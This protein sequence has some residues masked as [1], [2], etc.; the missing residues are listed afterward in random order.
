MA[1]QARVSLGGLVLGKGHPVAIMGVLNV[2]PESFHAGSVHVTRDD[3]V[4]AGLEMVEAGA[5]IL[6]VGA[7]TTAPYRETAID[8]DEEERRLTWAVEALAGKV[9]VPISAD[10]TRPDVARSALEA[11]ASVV[12]DQSGLVDPALA[13]VVARARVGVIL[14]A[15]PGAATGEADPVAAVRARMKAAM[16][17]ARKVGIGSDRIVLDPGIGFFRASAVPWHAWDVTVLAGL[18]RLNDLSQPLAVG[19]SRKSFLGEI[20]GRGAP[21]ARLAASL[22]AT[23]AAVLQGVDLV[24]THDVAPTVDAVRVAERIRQAHRP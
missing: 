1:A 8:A 18:P 4:G 13:D 23:A 2:S 20:T 16:A 11:G 12:N 6:D 22:A 15:A 9:T 17:R 19:V 24:R 14:M 7:R 21:E 10:T 3:L 5:D